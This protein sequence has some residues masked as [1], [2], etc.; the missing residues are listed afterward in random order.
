M[1]AAGRPGPPGDMR[2]FNR[3]LSV[4]Q[5]RIGRR[6]DH[7]NPSALIWEF[8]EFVFYHAECAD[9]VMEVK[10]DEGS[11]ACWCS[12]CDELRVFGTT[13]KPGIRTPEAVRAHSRCANSTESSGEG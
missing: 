3:G 6:A 1:S 12:P 5:D 13:G 7:A 2:R 4:P 11:I 8:A 9:E 10:L